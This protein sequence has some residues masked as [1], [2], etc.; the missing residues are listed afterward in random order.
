MRLMAA[1]RP[2]AFLILLAASVAVVGSMMVLGLFDL[3]VRPKSAPSDSTELTPSIE[4]NEL[5]TP[6]VQRSIPDQKAA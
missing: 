4:A 6:E 2:A 1:T 5:S 3:A